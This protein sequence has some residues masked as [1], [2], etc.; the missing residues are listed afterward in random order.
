MEKAAEISASRLAAK[1]GRRMRVLVDEIDP[2][3]G[4]AQARS[5]S[6]APEIDGQVLIE[7]ARHLVPGSWADVEIVASDTYDLQGELLET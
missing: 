3:T 1:I 2:E 4:V 5:A 7:D 6:D